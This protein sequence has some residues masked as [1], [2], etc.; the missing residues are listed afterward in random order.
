MLARIYAFIMA[1]FTSLALLG[2]LTPVTNLSE[3]KK[4]VFS[5]S[6]EVTVTVFMP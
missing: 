2:P 4:P 5:S 1:A 6:A 3:F